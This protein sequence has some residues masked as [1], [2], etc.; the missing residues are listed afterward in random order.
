MLNDVILNVANK[1]YTLSVMMLYIVML[2][3]TN[4]PFMLSV[5]MLNIVMLRVVVL[6]FRYAEL[7]Q[8]SFYAKYRYA[9]CRK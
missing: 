6:S 5:V 3:D 9:E 2:N 1:P 7:R 8:K 4:K